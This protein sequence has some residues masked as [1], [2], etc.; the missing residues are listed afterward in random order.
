MVPSMRLPPLPWADPAATDDPE[1]AV[2]EL[3]VEEVCAK[4]VADDA[5][6]WSVG[7]EPPQAA[8]ESAMVADAAISKEPRNLML[9]GVGTRLSLG[10]VPWRTWRER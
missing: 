2:V 10:L 9:S 1:D 4:E 5:A 8:S 3:S 6:G 7:D